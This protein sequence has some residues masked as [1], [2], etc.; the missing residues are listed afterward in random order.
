MRFY[1]HHVGLVYLLLLLHVILG[2]VRSAS[3]NDEDTRYTML[4]KRDLAKSE[5][6]AQD[7]VSKR[8]VEGHSY[9]TL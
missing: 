9:L 6:R 2:I 1:V 7:E 8:D 5:G 3:V 4:R